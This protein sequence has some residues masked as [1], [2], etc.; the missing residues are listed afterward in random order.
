M[1]CMAG[2]VK[3]AAELGTGLGINAAATAGVVGTPQTMAGAGDVAKALEYKGDS[4]KPPIAGGA[5]PAALPG[6]AATP[7][8]TFGPV[9]GAFALK[10]VGLTPGPILGIGTT[11]V[12]VSG[13]IGMF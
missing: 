4:T 5:E 11:A 10:A 2:D 8:P 13:G 12:M 6:V 9:P 3:L 7:G 1:A